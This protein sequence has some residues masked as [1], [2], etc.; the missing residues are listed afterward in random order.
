MITI[1]D[2]LIEEEKRERK[3]KEFENNLEFLYLEKYE[4]CNV[5][6]DNL[7]DN[8]PVRVIEINLY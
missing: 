5:K 2:L 8:K 4:N 1:L 6:K 7:K 3:N